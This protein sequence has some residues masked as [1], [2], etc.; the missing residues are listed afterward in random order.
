VTR[1]QISIFAF[2]V[3]ALTTQFLR[4]LAQLTGVPDLVS[5]IREPLLLLLFLWG[6]TR[7]DFFREG[8]LLGVAVAMVALF[9]VY[10]LTSA[11]QAHLF[12][13]LYYVR[14]YAIPVFFFVACHAA[15]RD[16]DAAQLQRVLRAHAWINILVLAVA[17]G[18]YALLQIHEQ[19]RGSLIGGGEL[20]TAWFI[21]G[22]L[23]MRMGLPFISPNNLGTYAALS[24]LLAAIVLLAAQTRVQDRRLYWLSL[25]CSLAA[26]AAS[27]S[28]SAMLL[29]GT[30]FLCLLM[31]PALHQSRLFGRMLGFAL[32]L[33]LL[34]IAGMVVIEFISDGYF[35]RWVELNLAG[36][37]PSLQ[38]H[39][40]TFVEAYRNVDS[41]YL[42]GYPHGT[43]GPKAYQF[44][45]RVHNAE[46][47]LLALIYDFGL[48]VGAVFI[49]L[50][51][52]LLSSA[53]YTRMQLAPLLGFI[54]N[55]QFLPIIFEPESIAY[56][57][58]VYLLLG[59]MA[60]AGLF[61]HLQRAAQSRRHPVLTGA[62][63]PQRS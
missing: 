44:T 18:V 39:I 45:L 17:F 12:A 30:A 22:G 56:F 36:R 1:A 54:V 31:L 47:S 35:S 15:L 13:G 10:L 9:S 24:A 51:G 21:S 32:T 46:N 37:D 59:H 4:Q 25:L 48:P 43:V 38:G 27:L 16:S 49:A 52:L 6:L 5:P 58:F 55:M 33:V 23:Y 8:R 40:E 20:A 42:F 26:L 2:L 62:T 57:L 19:W 7:L 29:L 60:R 41:N 34:V 14:L 53:W 11:F 63:A 61:E 3:I 28:R 50:Q